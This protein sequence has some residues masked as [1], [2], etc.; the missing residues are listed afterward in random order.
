MRRVSLYLM[1]MLGLWFS[2]NAWAANNSSL[3][4]WVD[5]PNNEARQVNDAGIR[6]RKAMSNPEFMLHNWIELPTSPNAKKKKIYKLSLREAI[7]L[8]LRYN[9]NIQNAEL[10]RIVQYYQ[11][12]LANNEFELQ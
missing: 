3:Y 12:R 6:L 9:P 4:K 1:W 10:D 2:L 5:D 11:L 8:A 7:L